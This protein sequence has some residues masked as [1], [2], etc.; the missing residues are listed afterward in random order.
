MNEDMFSM[1]LV[2]LGLMALLGTIAK[3]SLTIINRRRPELPRSSVS[4]DDLARQLT[5]LQQSVDATAVEVERLG[6]SQRF[7]T[8]LL[9]ERAEKSETH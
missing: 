9:A 3:I 4:L 1:L 6:E 2:F 8:K 5:A 7:T